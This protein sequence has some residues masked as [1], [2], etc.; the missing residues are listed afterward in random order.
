MEDNRPIAA[1]PSLNYAFVEVMLEN[2]EHC[3]FP[4]DGTLIVRCL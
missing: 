3:M 4:A 2:H 1:N